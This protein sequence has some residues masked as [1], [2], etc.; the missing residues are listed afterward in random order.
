ML[1][2][3]HNFFVI[4]QSWFI[5]LNSTRWCQFSGNYTFTGEMAKQDILQLNTAYANFSAEG[6]ISHY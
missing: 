3:I 6:H 5:E 2:S 4:I 1:A